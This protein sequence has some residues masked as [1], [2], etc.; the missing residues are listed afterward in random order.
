[1]LAFYWRSVWALVIGFVVSSGVK[2]VLSYTLIA[3]RPRFQLD[4][5][6]TRELFRYGRFITG[7]SILTFLA[8]EI[9][10]IAIAK[11]TTAT[12]LGYYTVAFTLATFPAAHVAFVISNV[13]FSVFSK[14][15][16]DSR[17]LR[18]TFLQLLNVVASLIIPVVAGM[19]AAADEIIGTLYG[20]TWSG[21]IIPFQYLCL[22]GALQAL[23]TAF[24]YVLSA[25]GR[26]EVSLRIAVVRLTVIGLAIVPAIKT[27]GITGAAIAMGIATTVAFIYGARTSAVALGVSLRDVAQVLL[28]V[29]AKSAAVVI[30]ILV[31]DAAMTP[32]APF[33]LAWLVLMGGLIYLP[34]NYRAARSV[35]L[36]S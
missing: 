13:M 12:Q 33:R 6:I 22:T 31:L 36:R 28:A 23:V 19:A 26:P 2:T 27:G 24:S 30:G 8:T 21:S 1:L 32:D 29:A 3:G 11:L 35:L 4:G 18:K 34:A 16:D 5:K 9:D 20:E 7:A 14:I 25:I 10:T 17:M 15:Q